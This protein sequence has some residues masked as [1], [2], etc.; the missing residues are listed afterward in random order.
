MGEDDES[1]PHPT[2]CRSS[3]I[4]HCMQQALDSEAHLQLTTFGAKVG[5]I[6][7]ALAWKRATAAVAGVCLIRGAR[8]IFEVH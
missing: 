3:E 8:G 4:Y 5:K 2:E 1:A 6:E 7:A